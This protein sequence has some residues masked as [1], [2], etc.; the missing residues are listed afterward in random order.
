[1]NQVSA[2]SLAAWLA[3]DQPELFVALVKKAMTKSGAQLGDFSDILS[4][5]GSSIGDAVS[6]VGSYLTS[7]QGL[8]ALTSLSGAYLTSQ[9]QKQAVNL[10]VARAQAG[11]SAAPIQT[12]FNPNT[13]QY[14]AVVTQPTGAVVPLTPQLQQSLI[15]SVPN[16]VLYAGGGLV[17]MFILFSLRR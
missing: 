14:Q 3:K 5:I 15:P 11:Q 4:S 1:M 16:W 2:Q 12:V 17:L 8:S 10:Q 9:A 7:S 6:N 13:N